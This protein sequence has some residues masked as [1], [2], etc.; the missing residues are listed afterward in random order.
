MSRPEWNDYFMSIAY[1]VS[2]R[3]TC[4]RKKVGAVLVKDRTIIS[5]GYNGAASGMPHCDE[6]GHELKD[7]EGRPS[8]VR[9]IHA[10]SNAIDQAKESLKYAT[11]YTNVIPCYDC[12]KRIVNAKI[13]RVYYA[14]YYASRNTELVEE[15]FRKSQW[16]DP[17]AA[18]QF[19]KGT[20]LIKW[21]G[22]FI[23]PLIPEDIVTRTALIQKQR[24]S[25]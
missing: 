16:V 10:E 2:S 9:T 21:E 5:T 6:I 17:Q 20:E 8:C 19:S 11:L 1:L 22:E 24:I 25:E 13:S 15:Y 18:D 23:T 14:E 12:A 4:D 3:A 7:I